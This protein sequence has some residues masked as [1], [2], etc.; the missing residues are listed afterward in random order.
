[1]RPGLTDTEM[2]GDPTQRAEAREIAKTGAP[3]GRMGTADEI[4]ALALFLCSDEA[5]YITGFS[6]DVSGGR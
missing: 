3:M 4:A 5:S 1:M 6:Y 2:F